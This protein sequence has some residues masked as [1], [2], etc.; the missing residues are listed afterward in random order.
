MSLILQLLLGKQL[1]ENRNIVKLMCERTVR[2]THMVIEVWCEKTLQRCLC[3]VQCATCLMNVDHS[4]TFPARNI[5]LCDIPEIEGLCERICLLTPSSSRPTAVSWFIFSLSISLSLLLTAVLALSVKQ[6]RK[7]ATS[8][9]ITIPQSR[10]E[11]MPHTSSLS[12]SFAL[13]FFKLSHVT[14]VYESLRTSWWSL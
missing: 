6:K 8:Q 14:L 1:S 2:I 10:W 5:H 3:S 12:D 9:H 4:L 11:I 13:V 7:R